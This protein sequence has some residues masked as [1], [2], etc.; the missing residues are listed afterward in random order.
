MICV[1]KYIMTH[2]F[3]LRF[4]FSSRRRHTRCA[5]VTGVQTCALPISCLTRSFF[6]ADGVCRTIEDF[7]RAATE[8][9]YA[10]EIIPK[11][12]PRMALFELFNKGNL[13]SISKSLVL[14]ASVLA[15]AL[16]QAAE[17]DQTVLTATRAATP[18]SHIAL[19]IPTI[20]QHELTTRPT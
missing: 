11:L 6:R 7:P 2:T 20:S 18:I 13:M 14:A 1:G 10:R 9:G 8:S 3:S 5:L 19:S 4:F 16:A 15:P 17:G 12:K